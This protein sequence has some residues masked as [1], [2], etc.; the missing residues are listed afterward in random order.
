MRRWN[1]GLGC[2]LAL[3]AGLAGAVPPS[4]R[5]LDAIPLH[6]LSQTEL[7]RVR[8]ALPPPTR[9]G[10]VR[11]A[12]N[13]PL[14][15]DLSDGVWTQDGDTAI[16]NA[17]VYSAGATLLIAAFDRVEL[18]EGAEL[19]FSD[20]AGTTVQGPYTAQDRTADGRLWT[21]MVPGEEGLIELRVPAALRDAVELRLASLGHGQYELRNDGVTPKSGSCNVDVACP[22]GDAWRNQIRSAVHL[23]IPDGGMFVLC[24]G[25]LVNN[26]AQND[27]PLVLT[28]THC[29]LSGSDA[30]N[31]TAYFNFQ[32]SSC[33][34]TPNGTLT[35]N[36]SGSTLLFAHVRS[37]HTLIRLNRAPNSAFNVHLSGF[38]ASDSAVPSSGVAIH[39][40]NGDEKRISTYS[41]PAARSNGV[42][43][44]ESV[45][46]ICTGVFIDTFRVNWNSGVTEPGSSGG[47]LW[48]QNQRLVGVL[49]GGN[50]SCSNPNGNDFFGRLDVAWAAGIDT[51]L[52]PQGT[53]LRN[54]AGKNPGGT[55]TT[56]GGTS[57]GTTTGSSS[58]GGGGGGGSFGAALVLLLAGVARM[59]GRATAGRAFRA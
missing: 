13:V 53:G 45:A 10:P 42:C 20:T 19:R 46:G 16:W 49:S 37:D 52:D 31:V 48:N 39:H 47:G 12:V 50:S 41:N 43:L 3:W 7:E 11:L 27:T 30:G 57:G 35:Q 54:V 44:G 21:A 23:Q 5:A 59:L 51:H 17:R 32:T 25:Q 18:P 34:G 26:T 6:V 40:P 2:A 56:T 29:G 38:D 33:G 55:T 28:A 36:Q 4:S 9:R 8:T 14:T 1:I 58:G 24:S 15:L 22:A